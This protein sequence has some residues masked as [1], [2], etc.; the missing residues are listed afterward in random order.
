MAP[1]RIAALLLAAALA[2]AAHG[3][4]LYKSVGPNGVIEFSDQPPAGNAK[5][6]EQRE[7]GSAIRTLP[8]MP[9]GGPVTP[10]PAAIDALEN[11]QEVMNAA[12]QVDL[13]EHAL[14]LARR[15][16]WSAT[17]GLKLRNAVRTT[18]DDERI[19]FYKRGVALAR[20]NLA[21]V[22]KRRAADLAA[23]GAPVVTAVASR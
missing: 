8:G 23:P 11:D 14:A 1:S 21:A 16:V 5:L 22:M 10:P 2:P 7:L 12:S 4:V 20:Q 17:D 6:V 15:G 19:E 9:G 13:A 3:A 18:S